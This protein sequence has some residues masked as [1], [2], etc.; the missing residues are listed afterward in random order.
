MAGVANGRTELALEPRE[1]A[2][3]GAEVAA[4]TQPRQTSPPSPQP[5]VAC[6][7]TMPV[8]LLLRCHPCQIYLLPVLRAEPDPT[9]LGDMPMRED[10]GGK[11]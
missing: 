6:R 8:K 2:R 1:R 4:S 3:R 7:W 11:G 5:Q 10:L 9:R